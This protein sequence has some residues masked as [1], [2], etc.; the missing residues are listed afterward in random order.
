[1]ASGA[2]GEVVHCPN[3]K[4]DVPK[5]LYCLNCGFPLYKEEQVKE[6]KPTLEATEEKKPEVKAEPVAP[7][8]D[9]VILVDDELGEEKPRPEPTVAM[10]PEPAPEMKPA[11]PAVAE[12]PVE[13]VEPV[14]PPIIVEVKPLDPPAE[15]KEVEA[16]KPEET[17]APVAEAP[18]P[19]VIEPAPPVAS[20]PL[21]TPG[22]ASKVE[23]VEMVEEYQE[24]AVKKGY[25]P[26]PLSKDLMENLSKSI[27]LRLK[28]VKLYR[29]GVMKEET[30]TKL[31]D[32]YLTEGRV[33][34]TRRDEMLAKLSGE[35]EEMEDSYVNAASALEF[36]E[37]K[38][39]IG[40]ISDDEYAAKSPAYRWDIDHFDFLAGEKR[41]K[42]AYLENIGV[43]LSA[44]ELKELRE[45]ASLQYNTVDALQMTSEEGLS[46]VKESLYEAIKT[47][48]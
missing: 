3:C 45:F 20:E 43:A 35:V 8:E 28:L 4:E 25:V 32:E 11:A 5:T 36:L 10:A 22:E 16:P 1:M 6:E 14:T 7:S 13:Q 31:F 26:D 24:E 19:Q 42:I 37:I 9:A 12:Q 21:S 38:K 27:S 44:E 40:D 17:V 33:W 2:S 23:A 34:S 15:A 47:L 48:G 18:P 39:S 30:F 46:R 29:E 41:N